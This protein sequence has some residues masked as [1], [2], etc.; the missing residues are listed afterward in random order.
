M[1]SKALALAESLLSASTILSCPATLLHG[2]DPALSVL[3]CGIKRSAA[4]GHL[5]LHTI[6]Q[7]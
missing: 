5:D 6:S 3:L 1:V 4:K 2:H 7:N